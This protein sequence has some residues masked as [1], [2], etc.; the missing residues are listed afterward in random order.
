MDFLLHVVISAKSLCVGG[1]SGCLHGGRKILEGGTTFRLVYMQKFRPNGYQVEKEKKKNCRLVAA[2]STA[3]AM[4]VLFVPS[5]TILARTFG[6]LSLFYNQ[7]NAILPPP[8]SPL[9]NVGCQ[10]SNMSR[11]SCSV[12]RLQ[13][14]LGGGGV[15]K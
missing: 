4:F 15:G 10:D 1:R 7:N 8:P 9:N 3:A 6:T 2:E 5:T 14:C 11:K 12:Y 13:H